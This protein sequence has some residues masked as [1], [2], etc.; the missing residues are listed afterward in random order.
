MYNACSHSVA[1]GY[2]LSGFIS[3]WSMTVWCLHALQTVR[4]SVPQPEK[5]LLPACR[6]VGDVMAPPRTGPNPNPHPHH[7]PPVAVGGS[8]AKRRKIRKGTSSCWECKRRKIRC[9]FASAFDAVCIG[10]Q[11]RGTSCLSQ[12]LPEEAPPPG[13]RVC[14]M[15]DRIGRVEALIDQL[16]E[17]IGNGSGSNI[18]TGGGQSTASDDGQRSPPG[19]LPTPCSSDAEPSRILALY[20]P[21]V[22]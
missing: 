4:S 11:R 3:S 15:G 1:S 14:Q 13:N 7:E 12:E 2:R 19:I 9:T 17:T 8:E 16:V 21:S 5:T 6:T 22:V 20:E 18:E 10:C